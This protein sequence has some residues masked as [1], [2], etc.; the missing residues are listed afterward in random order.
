MNET[1]SIGSNDVIKPL[2]YQESEVRIIR[3][4]ERNHMFGI[5]PE[6]KRHHGYMQVINK[7]LEMMGILLN[8]LIQKDQPKPQC[9]P[10]IPTQPEPVKPQPNDNPANEVR[11]PVCEAPKPVCDQPNREV[12]PKKEETKCEPPKIEPPVADT[13]KSKPV[14]SLTDQEKKM[15]EKILSAKRGKDEKVTEKTKVSE[16]DL[17]ALAVMSKMNPKLKKEFIENLKK[18]REEMK[19]KGVK[20]FFPA[21]DKAMRLLMSEGKMTK[22]EFIELKQHALGKAQLDDKKAELSTE[23]KVLGNGIEG[24]VVEKY[25]NNTEATMSQ[26]R[27]HRWLQDKW[28][29]Q[30]GV[31]SQVLSESSKSI[32]QLAGSGEFLWKPVSESN[33]KLVILTPSAFTG[34]VVGVTLQTASGRIIEQG[35]FKGVANGGREHFRFSKDGGSYPDGIVVVIKLKDGTAQRVVIK[36]TSARFIR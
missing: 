26:V 17:Y 29:R 2:P 16:E 28:E 9:P 27:K 21:V 10:S 19:K 22:K 23:R 32:S 20:E 1:S 36:E 25:K 7:L 18:S 8:R 30:T 34:K 35:Q 15:L 31:T 3:K 4:W 24:G 11:K 13:V 5:R 12:C 6:I 33:G 14:N